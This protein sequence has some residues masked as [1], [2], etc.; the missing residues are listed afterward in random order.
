VDIKQLKAIVDF[1]EKFN[2][3]HNLKICGNINKLD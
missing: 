3:K 1:I 2:E